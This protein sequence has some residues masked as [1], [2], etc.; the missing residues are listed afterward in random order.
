MFPALLA[1]VAR[2]SSSG[3]RSVSRPACSRAQPSLFSRPFSQASPS[4]CLA[5]TTSFR[6]SP[7]HVRFARL[8]PSLPAQRD[9]AE[10]VT[11][12]FSPRQ[13][14]EARRVSRSRRTARQ[15]RSRLRS[16]A[17]RW[18]QQWSAKRRTLNHRAP[19]VRL[20]TTARRY[21]VLR[22]PLS[23]HPQQRID[24]RRRA[25]RP[26][27]HPCRAGRLRCREISD[28]E[29]A[30]PAKLWVVGVIGRYRLSIIQA[31]EMPPRQKNRLAWIKGNEP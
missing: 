27:R 25:R 8:P 2:R 3:V 10:Q 6:S 11:E 23:L 1:L 28:A 20:I 13:Q 26:T 29:A 16:P 17:P 22:V 21:P 30:I 7:R 14:L 18:G 9:G 12:P 4:L 5:F 19:R 15:A 24:P 31:S